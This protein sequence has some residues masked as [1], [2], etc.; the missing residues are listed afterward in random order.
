MISSRY[1]RHELVV[2]F[3]RTF[4][5]GI[6]PKGFRGNGLGPAQVIETVRA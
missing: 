5:T 3:L 1:A 2:L 6:P 4:E